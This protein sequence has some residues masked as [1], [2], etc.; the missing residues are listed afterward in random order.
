MQRINTAYFY[1]IAQ[2]LVPL[3]SLVGGSKLYFDNYVTI[4]GAQEELRGFLINDVVPPLTSYKNGEE[5]FN[6]LSKITAE[7]FTQDRE[8]Q[9]F[10]VHAI[11]E[12]L[13][14][15]EIALQSDFGTRDTFIVSPKG[16]YSTTILAERGQT[17]VSSGVHTLVPAL[18][19]DLHDGCRC[20]AF[21]LGTAA[22][23]H[24]FRA[25]ESAVCS[26]GEFVRGKAFTKA[27]RSK[28]LGGYANALKQKL[29]GVDARIINSIEQIASLHRNPTMHPEMHIST[30]EALATFGMT[31]SVI[32]TIAIDWN[33]RKTT[34]DVPLLDI[35]PD[36]SKVTAL[37]EETNEDKPGEGAV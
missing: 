35:L 6:T 3:R 15:F 23:F 18:E 20:L 24:F 28:G 11:V 36:D 33:R 25:V 34:P 14:H 2:K 5:L 31:V 21:E 29:L 27:E 19:R 8:L 7:E 10:E 16:A 37:L 22:A 17:S 1:R 12:A 4:S 9:Y 26:Y 30:T 32:E 13:N